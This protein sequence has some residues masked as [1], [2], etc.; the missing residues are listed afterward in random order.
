MDEFRK[1]TKEE[2]KTFEQLAKPNML[3]PINPEF[4]YVVKGSTLIGMLNKMAELHRLA[5]QRE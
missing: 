5:T 2:A 4:D 1:L 3:Q